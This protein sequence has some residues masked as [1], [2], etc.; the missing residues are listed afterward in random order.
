MSTVDARIPLGVDTSGFDIGKALSLA[1]LSQKMQITKQAIQ[2]QNALRTVFSNPASIDANGNPT[3][4]AIQQVMAV[5]PQAGMQLRETQLEGQAKQMQIKHYET[6]IGKSKFDYMSGAAGAAVDAYNAKI[7]AGGTPQEASDAA[8]QARNS[9]IKENGGILNEN[10]VNSIISKPFQLDQATALAGRNPDWTAKQEKKSD[11]AL[12]LRKAEEAER[13]DK[14][15]QELRRQDEIRREKHDERMESI[16]ARNVSVREKSA[17]VGSLDGDTIKTMAEQYL[18]GDKSVLS[19]LGRG[20]Q[21]A[22][23]I[24][25][26]RGEIAKQ[27][28][29]QGMSGADVAARIAEFSG[30]TAGERTLGTRTAT[31]GMAATEAKNLIPQALLTSEKVDRTKYK[32]L[33]DVENAFNKGT[34]DENVVRFFQANNALINTYA[35]AISPTGAPTVSDKDHAREILETGFSKGQYK[36]AVDQMQ[37]EIDAALKSPGQVRGE[38]R[39]AIS[40]KKEGGVAVPDQPSTAKPPAGIP[41][42]STHIGHTPDGREVWQSADGKK[43]VQ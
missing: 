36:A 10:E 26:L 13:K 14:E 23:N 24:V 20:A 37:K 2:G 9:T 22:G 33:N 40:G 21:G 19:N 4:Q 28:A 27:A 35:R 6:E 15:S 25:K 18:A 32:S 7:A 16:A 34:G 38:F 1:E 8:M 41:K 43:W 29:E 12:A 30:L 31:A 42:G 11:Q 39:E 5:D 17:D 3:P